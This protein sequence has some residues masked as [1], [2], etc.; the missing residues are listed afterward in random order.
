MGKAYVRKSG[1]AGVGMTVEL[2]SRTDCAVAI[3]RAELVLAN[4]TRVAA[5]IRDIAPLVGRSLAYTWLAF[6]FDNNRAWNDGDVDGTFEL[7][8][9]LNGEP[10]PTWRMPA[11]HDFDADGRCAP[12]RRS[13]PSLASLAVGSSVTRGSR[14]VAPGPRCN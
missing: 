9:V 5:G 11:H 14:R 4:G 8:L 3:A 13:A 7:D 10:A 6:P 1:K 12:S 2:R